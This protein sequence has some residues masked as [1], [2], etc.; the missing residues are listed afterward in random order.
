M[1]G[2]ADWP[3]S[4]R[5]HPSPPTPSN[6][7]RHVHCA[8]LLHRSWGSELRPPCSHSRCFTHQPHPPTP[9]FSDD[10][11]LSQGHHGRARTAGSSPHQ[12]P[13]TRPGLPAWVFPILHCGNVR[14][15]EFHWSGKISKQDCHRAGME[16]TPLFPIWKNKE[17]KSSREAGDVLPFHASV[18]IVPTTFCPSPL[19]PGP[20]G[21]SFFTLEKPQE[22]IIKDGA[23]PGIPERASSSMFTWPVLVQRVTGAIH[24]NDRL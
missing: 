18:D 21:E 19:Q 15:R 6:E 12:S 8:G 1:I 17:D 24:C 10:S 14:H 2:W 22:L 20:Q 9:H 4:S 3:V 7:I 13:A 11:C 5:I 23:W 16:A